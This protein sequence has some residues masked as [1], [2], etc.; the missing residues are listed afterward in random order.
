MDLDELWAEVEGVARDHG[1]A[2]GV[3]GVDGFPDVRRE[4]HDRSSNGRRGRLGFTYSDIERSTD[5]G[6][7]FPWARRLVTGLHP[8]LPE[9][10][11]PGPAEPGTGRVARFAAGDAYQPLRHGLEAMAEVIGSAGWRTEV[12]SDDSRLVDRAAAVRA[13][14]GWWGKNTMVLAPGIGPWFLI[15]TVVTDA[16]FPVST[17]MQRNCGTCSA[18]LPACPTGALV[19][20]GVLDARLC[21]AA[22]AQA[23]GII[24]RDLRDAMGDRLYGCDDCLDACPPGTRVLETSTAPR[25]RVDLIRILEADDRWILEEFSHFFIPRRDARYL[26]RNALVAL[27][28][29]GD[30]RHRAVLMRYLRHDD[31]LLRLHAVWAVARLGG[32]WSSQLLDDQAAIERHSDVAAEIAWAREE[33]RRSREASRPGRSSP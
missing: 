6:L 8:Y 3:A 24:P 30:D 4:M 14:I 29:T 1:L 17:P 32:S 27:G 22:L 13:G 25:G 28:N 9:A 16:P 33:V 2:I 15:G 12:V 5:P 21:L 7:A 11:S 19:A 10:G 31:W 26:R 20:P 18:C 23:P